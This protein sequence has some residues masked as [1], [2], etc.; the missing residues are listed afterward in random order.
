M[1]VET[2][3]IWGSLASGRKSDR[4]RTYR[5]GRVCAEPDCTT[6]LSAYNPSPRCAVHER[7]E[8]IVRLRRFEPRET[9]QHCA[10]CGAP[11]VTAN[12]RRKFCSA[13][14]RSH[15]FSARERAMRQIAQAG[16]RERLAA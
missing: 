15:A 1:A 10:H 2:S 12:P 3:G 11:F 4:V 13:R 9:E 14:C 7:R 8:T 6:L 5:R 16:D